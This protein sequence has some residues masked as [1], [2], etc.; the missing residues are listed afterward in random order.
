MKKH[1]SLFLLVIIV[2]SLVLVACKKPSQDESKSALPMV[3]SQ[4]DIGQDPLSAP[5]EAEPSAGDVYPVGN[6]PTNMEITYPVD[7][8]SPSYNEEMEAWLKQL[9]GDKHT[10]DFV[11]SQ[12][13]TE[14][15]WRELFTGPDHAHLELTEGEL[16]VLINWLLERGN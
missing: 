12:T 1:I 16:Q 10:L 11:L 8:N 13:K 15:E 2:F 5:G 14:A 3:S 9:I 7:K 6:A 4:G